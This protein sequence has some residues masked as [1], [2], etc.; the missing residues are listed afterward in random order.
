MSIQPVLRALFGYLF[1]VL[2]VRIVGRRPGRQLTPFEHVLVFFLG[3]LMLTAIVTEEQSTTNAF[4]QIMAVAVA[5]YALSYA[6][7]RSD[8]AAKVL[9]GVPLALFRARAPV[10]TTMRLMRVTGEDL[11]ERARA[12]GHRRIES[13]DRAVLERNGDISILPR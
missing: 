4:C 1:L 6:R 10:R 8:L 11:A 3:G 13:I 7:A 5:H 2:L 12:Q 9:D